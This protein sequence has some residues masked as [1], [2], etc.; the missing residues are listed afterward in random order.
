MRNHFLSPLVAAAACIAACG[1]P[2]ALPTE[3]TDPGDDGPPLPSAFGWL[4]DGVSWRSVEPVRVRVEIAR[5]GERASAFAFSARGE[6]ADTSGTVPVLAWPAESP[7]SL[8]LVVYFEDL[9]GDE[10]EAFRGR[11]ETGETPPPAPATLLRATMIDVGWGDA[12]LLETPSGHRILIDAGSDCSDNQASLR[13][14]LDDRITG[15]GAVGHDIDHVFLTHLHWD[16]YTGLDDTILLPYGTP[17]YDVGTVHFSTPFVSK[18]YQGTYDWLAG[19]VQQAGAE[20]STPRSA[21]VLDLAPDLEALVLNAGN[22]FVPSSW[23][24]ENENNSSFVLRL[25]Y[26]DVSLV[27]TGDAE[28]SLADRLESRFAEALEADVLKVGHHGSDDATDGSWVEAVAPTVALVPI[29]AGQV[30]WY[31]PHDDVISLLRSNGAHVFRSDSIVPG[32]A[33]RRDVTGHVEVLS[34]GV[35]VSVRTH[36]TDREPVDCE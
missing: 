2:E 30:D 1:Q 27:Y 14:F 31:L 26:G 33:D 18:F 36:V 20:R 15:P 12:H 9:A 13:A 28:E 8:D 4:G 23:D 6:S 34:D 17:G 11:V 7:D 22:P 16:H 35:S 32:A 21:D 3:N 5:P 29:D 24:G 25:T 10:T 19:R